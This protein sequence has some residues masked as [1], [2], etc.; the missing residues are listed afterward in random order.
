MNFVWIMFF[1]CVACALIGIYHAAKNQKE[2][3]FKNKQQHEQPNLGRYR[4]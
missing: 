4:K 2:E 3:Q 1:M